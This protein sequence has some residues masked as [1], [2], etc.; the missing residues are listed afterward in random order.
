MFDVLL[1]SS[2]A[3]QAVLIGHLVG[4]CLR[5]RPSQKRP[6]EGT[7]IMSDYKD[8][9]VEYYATAIIGSKTTLPSHSSAAFKESNREFVTLDVLSSKLLPTAEKMLLRSPEVTL[10]GE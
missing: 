9:I 2:S 5:L 1:K 10:D 4:V 3:K 8:K 6:L 7:K